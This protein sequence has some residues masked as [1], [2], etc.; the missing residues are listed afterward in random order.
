MK[1]Y[2]RKYRQ[3]SDE[4]K[5]KISISAKNKPKSEIHKQHIKQSM[6]RY[7]STVENKPDSLSM[8][9]YLNKNDDNK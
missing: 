7:W 3:L 9:D 1:K 4:T 6:L 2:K 5:S 8:D